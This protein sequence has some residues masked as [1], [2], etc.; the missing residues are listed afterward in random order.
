MAGVCL[1]GASGAETGTEA[2]AGAEAGIMLVS[3]VRG[4]AGRHSVRL[5]AG[6]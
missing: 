2:R 6:R 1:N 3:R 4:E 5:M